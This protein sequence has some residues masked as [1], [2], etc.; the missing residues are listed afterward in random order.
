MKDKKP[1]KRK[2]EES[3]SQEDIDKFREKN[4]V[5]KKVVSRAKAR[6]YHEA[7]EEL[8]NKEDLSKVLKML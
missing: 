2:L 7:Y 8:E 5:V 3:L 1:T 6:L 4:K